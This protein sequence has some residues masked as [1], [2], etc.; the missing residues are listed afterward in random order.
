VFAFDMERCLACG[1]GTLRII[2]AITQAEVIRKILRHLKLAADPPPIA[3][4]WICQGRFAWT[5]P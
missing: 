3:E 1:R 2:A 5:S 4:A